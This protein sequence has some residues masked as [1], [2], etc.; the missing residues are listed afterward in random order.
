LVGTKK[1]KER[2]YVSKAQ[3]NSIVLQLT[4]QLAT[5]KMTQAISLSGEAMAAMNQLVNVPV[6]SAR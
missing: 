5:I 4:E 2:L 6:L 3:L 1:A